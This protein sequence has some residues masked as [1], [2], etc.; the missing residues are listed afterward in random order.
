MLVLAI[1]RLQIL[2]FTLVLL[3]VAM[4]PVSLWAVDLYSQNFE[5][6]TLGPIVTYQVMQRERAA[7]TATPPSGMVVDN[8][9]MPAGVMADPN[10]GVTEFEGWTFVD[11]A[12]WIATA[13]DQGRSG[14]V[15]G[16]GKI[17][18]ADND[19]HDDWGNPDAQGPFDSTLSTPSIALGGA[20]PNTVNLNF[21]SSWVPEEIQKAT[22]TARYNNGATVEVLRW[23]SPIADPKFHDT[24]T[25]E[26][27]VVPLQNPAGAT[28]VT[29]DFRCFD[30]TNNW[31]WAIDD[32]KVYTGATPAADGVLRA[33][34]DRNSGNVKIVN[35]T[36]AAVS[37]RGYSL[38]SANGAFNEA[39]AAFRAD[40]DPNWV[41]FTAPGATGD[42]SEGHKTSFSLAAGASI[43]FGN[44]VWRKFYQDASDISFQYLVAGNDNPIPALVEITGNS[45][46]SYPF[47]D[48]NFNGT[49]DPGDWDVFR[50]GFPV[51]LTGLSTVQKYQLGDLDNDGQHTPGDFLRFRTEYNSALGAG[52]FELLTSGVPE[53][54]TSW[55]VFTAVILG[56][57]SFSRHR[58]AVRAL[59]VLGI[60]VLLSADSA[61]AQLTLFSENFD[62][63]TLGPNQEEAVAGDHVW[64]KTAPVGWVPNDSGVPG[65]NNTPDN[66]G[67]TEWAGWSFADKTWWATAAGDQDRSKFERASGTVMVAD[68]DEWDDAA[69][70]VGLYNTFI[71]TPAIT[72]PAGIP[73]GRIKLGFDSSWRPEGADDDPNL[74]NNQRAT[75]NVTYNGGAPTNILTFDSVPGPPNPG[76]NYHADAP[77]EAIQRDLQYNGSSTSMTLTFGLDLAENDWWWAV[78]NI[79]VFVPANPLILRVNLSSG[80]AT[81]IGDD[82]I[83]TPVNFYDVTSASGALVGGNL[84]GLAARKPNSVDGSDPDSTVGN[85]SGEFWQGLSATNSRVTE[86]FLLGSSSFTN[87]RSESL[88]NIFNT[89]GAQD[90]VFTYTNIFGDVVNGVVQYFTPVGVP[91]DYNNNGVVDAADYVLWRNG[92]PLQNEVDTPGVVNAADYA[93]WRSRLGNTSGSGAGIGSASVP[94]PGTSGVMICLMFAAVV[95]SR[96]RY[97]LSLQHSLSVVQLRVPKLA[98][99]AVG[100]LAGVLVASS[101]VAVLP[102]PPVLDRNY[103][104]GEGE[105]GIAGNTVS[106]TW[107][108]AGAPG[109]QQLIDLSAIGSPKYEALP[110]V[111]GGPVPKRPDNATGIAI[112]LNPTSTSQGQYLKTGF[113]QALNFPE[114][115]Y[116]ST[117]QAGGTIDYS[118]IKDRGFQLWVLP[119]TAARADIVMDTNQHG[120]LIN[121]AGHFAM[122]YVNTDYDTGVTVTPNTWYHLMV[123]RPFGPGRG[124]IMYIN[125]KAVARASGVYAGE[126]NPANEETTPLVI[127]ANT[128]TAPFQI[129]AINRFQGLVDDLEMSVMGL[130]AVAD[131]GDFV[132]ERDNKYAA[133]FK[134]TNPAD[135]NGDNIINGTDVTTFAS[136]W[137]SQNVVNGLAIGDLTSRLNGDLNY[138]GFVNLADWDILNDAH[139]AAAAAAMA[140]IQAQVPEPTSVVLALIGLIAWGQCRRRS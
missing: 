32:I 64:T 59:V 63:L 67:V 36:G 100:T 139:P 118:F 27:V 97:N 123:T 50:A 77:N 138:D 76:P 42:L 52:A 20:A 75:V 29:L 48:L 14:F 5:N 39:N 81:I 140:L 70:P 38:L 95:F 1:R 91:G 87:S 74:A 126:D 134:P 79:R 98:V 116:S 22:V 88:G 44:N 128:S 112:R 21:H 40:S 115:S 105:G 9:L 69:H 62:G 108:T 45:G 94:E 23:T 124:S 121:L 16:L 53:P 19:T 24:A 114:R 92:G 131:Y 120:A 41:Q 7:W 54:C 73:A 99:T 119:Q 31:W 2:V 46:S 6:V 51:S 28:S 12:W 104:M 55:L 80:Q 130:N 111:S 13:G 122:R 37:L 96:H 43:D 106:V 86:A 85:T 49:I 56:V 10:E 66:N 90:L 132:F 35:N 129:G 8:S 82:V 33:I 68:P 137:L 103:R 25:N 34:V 47:L 4:C 58:R 15:S 17:A 83:A 110:T 3:L 26:S 117:F 89:A 78:D 60:A 65:I 135:V 127:G 101:A 84:S 136:H 71:T 102:P 109:M 30:A 11:K 93:A 125:G 18:V 72:I 133:F 107:D 57:S 113:E 61:H